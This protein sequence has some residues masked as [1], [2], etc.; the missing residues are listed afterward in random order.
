MAKKPKE[1]R[2]PEKKSSTE[3][4]GSNKQPASIYTVMLFVSVLAIF[5]GCIFLTLEMKAYDWQRSVPPGLQG[6]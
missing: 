3:A 5:L 6:R 1:S 2:R 4:A